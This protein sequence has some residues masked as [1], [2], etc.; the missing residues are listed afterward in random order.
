MDRAKLLSEDNIRACFN[1]FDH[2]RNGTISL[3]ELQHMFGQTDL[4]DSALLMDF[5]R[6]ADSNKDGVIDFAEFKDVLLRVM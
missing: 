1:M 2:D 5:L 3:A 4:G 6:G